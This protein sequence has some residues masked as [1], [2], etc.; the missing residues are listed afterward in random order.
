MFF[1]FLKINYFDFKL[2]LLSSIFILINVFLFLF[3]G[4]L[5]SHMID[6]QAV[7][8]TSSVPLNSTHL[9]NNY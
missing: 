7:N 3:L 6:V 8:I 4:Y 1:F 2:L 5:N 9:C